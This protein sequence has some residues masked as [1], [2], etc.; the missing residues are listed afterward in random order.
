M[1]QHYRKSVQINL[2]VVPLWVG[3]DDHPKEP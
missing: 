3:S 2:E 1:V